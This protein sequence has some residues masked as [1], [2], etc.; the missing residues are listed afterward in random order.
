MHY[1]EEI[2]AFVPG[3]EQEESDKRLM[4]QYQELF[5]D[6]ILFR[7]CEMAHLTSS[8]MIFNRERTKVLMV[9]HNIFDSWSWT[10]G[11]ADGEP[12]GLKTAVKEAKEETGITNIRVLK[13]QAVSLDILG[14]QPHRKRGKAVSAH[15][16]LN[17]TYLL[18]ADEEEELHVCEGENSRVGWIPVEEL[19]E[20]VSEKHMLP[21]YHKTIGRL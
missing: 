6:G 17:L 18:E 9:Y 8:S 20:R 7:T 21:V 14:V 3:C 2:R 16:H 19:E 4:L 10:G 12:D 1:L 13:P 15:V 5:G 11:H